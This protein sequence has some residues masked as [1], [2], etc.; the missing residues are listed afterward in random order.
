[1][2]LRFREAVEADVP[3][4]VALLLDDDL[5][6]TREN[7]NDPRYLIA[8]RAMAAEP[9]NKM[10]VGE[11]GSRVVAVYQFTLITGLSL[12]GTR[13]AQI[14][15]VRVA[16]DQRGQGIGAALIEDAEARARAGGAGLLQFTTNASRDRAQDFYRRM[17]FVDSHIGFKK[18]LS[19]E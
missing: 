14:E 9:D 1:M 18:P 2:S 4:I 15:G 10:I 8:F 17:G 3:G 12:G 7:L 13:R 11:L 6:R 16:S 5:G 19:P